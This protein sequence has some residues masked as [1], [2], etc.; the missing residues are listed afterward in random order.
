MKHPVPPVWEG[1]HCLKQ[2]LFIDDTSLNQGKLEKISKFKWMPILNY[3]TQLTSA[4]FSSRKRIISPVRVI[5][6]GNW[7]I[8]E[9]IH[10]YK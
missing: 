8:N 10:W 6:F 9:E 1:P 7:N 4:F 2:N 3:T 5:L